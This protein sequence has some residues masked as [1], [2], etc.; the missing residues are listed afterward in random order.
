[1]SKRAIIDYKKTAEINALKEYI[2]MTYG[3][4][5]VAVMCAFVT[6]ISGTRSKGGERIVTVYHNDLDYTIPKETPKVFARAIFEDRRIERGLAK[7]R[8]R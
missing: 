7:A 8:L 1:M 4:R 6:S 3:T 2:H 5:Y